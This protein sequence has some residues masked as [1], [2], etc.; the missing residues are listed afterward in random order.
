MLDTLFRAYTPL[1]I[2]PGLGLLLLRFVP[3]RFPQLLGQALYWV[4]VPLQL[5][6]LG[7]QTEWSDRVGFIPAVA[8]GVLLLSL[9]LSLIFWWIA[10][11]QSRSIEITADSLPSPVTST[12]SSATVSPRATLG[13]F[14]LAAMLGNTGFVGL[15]LAQVL[16]GIDDL[17]WAVLFSVTS[18]VAGN[19]GIAVFIAS[20]F[21]HSATKNHWWIQLRDVV[22]VPSTWA[23]FLGFS[24]R[25]IVLPEAIATGLDQAVWVVMASALLLVGLR[26]GS[27]KGWRS[28]QRAI[29]PTLLKVLIVPGLVGLGATCFGVTGVPRLV[30]VL[31]SGTPTGLSVL[32]LAEVYNLDRELLTGSIALSFIGLLLVLPLWLTWFS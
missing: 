19:Y 18:N 22:T 31:M 16:F 14:I 28:L 13:S 12:S 2:W 24:T 27:I 23:F 26:L 17:G 8:V 11:R 32:I 29:L 6:V 10:Q 1:L 20:Y 30:L 3:E 25:S 21:G 9:G 5:L 7:R 4:G 15:A